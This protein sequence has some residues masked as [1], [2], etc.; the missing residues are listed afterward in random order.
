MNYLSYRRSLKLLE[1]QAN[2]ASQKVKKEMEEAKKKYG[3]K[4]ADE[5]WETS[6]DDLLF[7][8]EQIQVLKT[9]YLIS[10]ISSSFYSAPLLN[11]DDI[12]WDRSQDTGE[13]FLTDEGFIEALK[14]KRRIKDDRIKDISFGV[15]ILFGLLGLIIGIIAVLKN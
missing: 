1:Q 3:K 12:N 10:K 9:E 7:H 4:A 13:W 5:I 2:E 14:I 6:Q 8:Y 15:S 11:K